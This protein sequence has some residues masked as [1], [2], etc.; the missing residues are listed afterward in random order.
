MARPKHRT[1]PGGTYF[2][3]TD[4]AQRR[5][6]FQNHEAAGIFEDKLIEYRDR[7]FYFL[8]RYTVMPDHLHAV[9]TPGDTTTLEKALQ[10]IKEARRTRSTRS[11]NGSFPSGGQ[12]SPNT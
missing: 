6:T 4:T 12:G 3:T 11:S 10:L 9:I 7:G 2:I 8:H 5:R 1:K